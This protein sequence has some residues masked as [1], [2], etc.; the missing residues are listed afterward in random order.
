MEKEVILNLIL[1]FGVFGMAV[2]IQ[3][4]IFSYLRFRQHMK[5]FPRMGTISSISSGLLQGLKHE[6]NRM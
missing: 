4:A 1:L 3:G 2:C 5:N 6:S